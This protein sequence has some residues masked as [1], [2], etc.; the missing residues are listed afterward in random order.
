MNLPLCDG[1]YRAHFLISAP[2]QGLWSCALAPNLDNLHIGSHCTYLRSL[3]FSSFLGLFKRRPKSP[4]PRHYVVV[5]ANKRYGIQDRDLSLR[6]LSPP[7]QITRNLSVD[8]ASEG[9]VKG[10]LELWRDRGD[11]QEIGARSL[12]ESRLK[13]SRSR[14]LEGSS[15][16]EKL[17]DR[18]LSREPKP[19]FG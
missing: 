14:I 1:L 5:D 10:K 19:T 7:R 2:L 6:K 3:T 16:A 18:A 4:G 13:F 12:G 8:H 17:L 15:Q 11:D 9:R